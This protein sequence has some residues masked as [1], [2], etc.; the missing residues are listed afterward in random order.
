MKLTTI[1]YQIKPNEHSVTMLT[2]TVN[3]NNTYS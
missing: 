1:F 3:K 2:V